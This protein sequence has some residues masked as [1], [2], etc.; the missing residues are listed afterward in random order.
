[1]C[2]CIVYVHI[3]LHRFINTSS[4]PR[5]PDVIITTAKGPEDGSPGS[6]HR[7]VTGGSCPVSKWEKWGFLK[8]L[9]GDNIV[10]KSMDPWEDFCGRLSCINRGVFANRRA[11][12][13]GIWCELLKRMIQSTLQISSFWNYI[14]MVGSVTWSLLMYLDLDLLKYGSESIFLQDGN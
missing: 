14:N 5:N 11:F 12:I 2:V 9:G 10:N 4:C 1:M 3:H 6:Q 7:P 8:T 13:L